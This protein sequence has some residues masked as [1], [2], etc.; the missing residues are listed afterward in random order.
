MGVL[1]LNA[2]IEAAR[3]GEDGERFLHAAEEIKNT[4]QRYE[5]AL[6]ALSEQISAVAEVQKEV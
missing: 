4:S 1:A 3:M 2:A 5:T 6:Q